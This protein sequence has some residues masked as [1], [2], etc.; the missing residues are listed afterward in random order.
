MNRATR[1]AVVAD[2]I[3]IGRCAFTTDVHSPFSTVITEG[4]VMRGLSVEFAEQGVEVIV[5]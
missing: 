3:K 4:G 2:S 5:A 1:A